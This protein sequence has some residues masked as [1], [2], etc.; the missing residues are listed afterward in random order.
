MLTGTCLQTLRGHADYVRRRRPDE[1]RVDRSSTQR[2]AQVWCVAVMSNGHVVSG[3][4]DRT[5]MVWD[6]SSG[7]CLKTLRG[8]TGSVRRRRPV[9]QSVDR[10]STQQRAQV[11][12][13]VALSNDRVVSGSWDNT[14]KVWDASTGRCLQTLTGHADPVRCLCPVEPR[15]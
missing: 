5:V 11:W 6:A 10:S 1:Q 13:V 4:G 7:E 8:H 12:C 15:F 3:S 14:L 9:K 2:G